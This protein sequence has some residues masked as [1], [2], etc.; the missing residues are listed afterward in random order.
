ME[1]TR[2]EIEQKIKDIDLILEKYD[3]LIQFLNGYENEDN[4]IDNSLWMIQNFDD[5]DDFEDILQKIKSE[6]EL[7]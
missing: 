2:T 7:I 3:S 5:I 4:H 1:L 6:L